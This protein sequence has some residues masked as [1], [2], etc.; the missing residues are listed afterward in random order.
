MRIATVTIEGIAP[1]QMSRNH[2]APKKDRETADDYERR[3]WIEKGHYT[4]SGQ[5]YIPQMAMKQALTDI[6]RYLGMQIPGKGK[7]T[8]TKHFESGVLLVEPILLL[9]PGKPHKPITRNDIIEERYYCNADGKRGSAKRVWRHFPTVKNWAATFT[10]DILD[11]TITP[12]VFKHHLE[13]AGKFKGVGRFRPEKGG[14]YGR[15]A[16]AAC[17]VKTVKD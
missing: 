1:Y 3:T 17:D 7:S 11:N 15:F 6:A 10:V 14:F 12:D 2:C 4:E 8:Y 13:Q 16:V 5:V 9:S